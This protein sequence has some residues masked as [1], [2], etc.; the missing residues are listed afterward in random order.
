[1]LNV[2]MNTHT[3][4]CT[5]TF[6]RL[7]AP[8]TIMRL[9]MVTGEHQVSLAS[10]AALPGDQGLLLVECFALHLDRVSWKPLSWTNS[11]DIKITVEL[12]MLMWN[13]VEI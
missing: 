8:R 6:S 13:D 7:N 1:M 9:Q 2:H 10:S 3:G 4:T 11:E 12:M 5:P